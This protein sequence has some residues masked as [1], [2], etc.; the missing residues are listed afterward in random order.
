MREALPHGVDSV[1]RFLD[2]LRERAEQRVTELQ[3]RGVKDA[4][5]YGADAST[6]PGTGKLNAFFLLLDQPEAYN[7][8]PDPVVPTKV[9][10]SWLSLGAAALGMAALAFGAV[11]ST[12]GQ[13]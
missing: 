1:R 8:P 3:G 13:P 4:Y 9:A 10:A 12:K 6:T 5:L 7:L 11:W 2:E